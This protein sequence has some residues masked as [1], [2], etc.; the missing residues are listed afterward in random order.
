MS[1]D[2]NYDDMLYNNGNNED[3]NHTAVGV[4]V[5]IHLLVFTCFVVGPPPSQY[6]TWQLIVECKPE[7]GGEAVG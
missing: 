3:S 1:T 5:S 6:Y 2:D 7:K 4:R